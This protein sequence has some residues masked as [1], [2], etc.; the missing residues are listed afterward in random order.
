MQ[1]ESRDDGVFNLTT[2]Y[3]SG[4]VKKGQY[5]MD[6][7]I[8]KEQFIFPIPQGSASVTFQI[9]GKAAGS[10]PPFFLFRNA[11]ERTATVLLTATEMLNGEI[12][13]VRNASSWPSASFVERQHFVS[14]GEETQ[15][16]VQ[17]HDPERFLAQASDITYYWSVNDVNY[18]TT[19]EPLFK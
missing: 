4:T 3:K 12:V 10:F 9:T 14:T 11:I 1:T 6:V 7:T 5:Q 17:F 16:A 15:L 8:Y 19:K 18:G 2:S 13:V